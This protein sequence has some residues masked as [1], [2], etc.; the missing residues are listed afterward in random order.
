MSRQ[1]GGASKEAKCASPA[2]TRAWTS[3]ELE[4]ARRWV[5]KL[6]PTCVLQG[7]VQQDR[8]HHRFQV[9]DGRRGKDLPPLVT[10]RRSHSAPSQGEG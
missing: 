2:E 5:G 4:H 3:Q 9:H 8:P 7:G 10:C 6:Q 1:M